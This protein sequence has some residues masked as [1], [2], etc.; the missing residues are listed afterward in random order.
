MATKLSSLASW[1]PKVYSLKENDF[2][3]DKTVNIEK[4]SV[5]QEGDYGLFFIMDC[6]LISFDGSLS[7]KIVITTGATDIVERLLPLVEKINAGE[8]VQGT[9]SKIGRK[10]FID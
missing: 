5:H 10:W 4:I 7:D 9:F 3:K 6:T 1:R 8:L 2:L